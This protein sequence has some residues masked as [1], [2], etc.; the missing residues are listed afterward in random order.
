MLAGRRLG[1]GLSWPGMVRRWGRVLMGVGACSTP[2]LAAPDA[3][4]P[5]K[6][7]LPSVVSALPPSFDWKDY[8]GPDPGQY[9]V[10]V[11]C[12]TPGSTSCGTC[13][14][15]WGEAA[16]LSDGGA[17]V[18]FAATCSGRW[19]NAPRPG[20][21]PWDTAVSVV[22]TQGAAR[23]V[24]ME[25]ASTIRATNVSAIWSVSPNDQTSGDVGID[26]NAEMKS[27]LSALPL[28]CQWTAPIDAGTGD[29]WRPDAISASDGAGSPTVSIPFTRCAT[30]AEC[31]SGF[32]VACLSGSLPS[33]YPW[34]LPRNRS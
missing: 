29:A 8:T 32:C 1:V 4:V 27:A 2:V 33:H 11:I 21:N 19:R 13:D 9:L 34:S 17:L 28:G 22:G 18:E 3:S 10:T 5:C 6:A 14:V 26:L 24:V 15:S 7:L 16:S 25:G 31:Q 20:Q 30:D 12:P 23:L